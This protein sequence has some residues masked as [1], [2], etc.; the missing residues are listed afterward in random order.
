M[1]DV[2]ILIHGHHLQTDNWEDVV[3][4]DPQNGVLGRVPRA[5]R[6][7]AEYNNPLLFWGSGGSKQGKFTEA[8]MSLNLTLQRAQEIPELAGKSEI[9]VA[10]YLK[11]M[12]HLNTTALNTRQEVHA[13]AV[14]CHAQTIPKM[15]LVSSPTHISRCMLD[16][17]KLRADGHMEGIRVISEASD[18]SYDGYTPHDVVVVEPPHRGDIQQVEFHE[19]AKRFFQFNEHP[20]LAQD[21]YYELDL[22]IGKYEGKMKG[23]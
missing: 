20:E 5:L 14:V 18:V 23:T 15:I 19:I 8:E 4:G 9:E 1:H 10:E 22:L 3:W 11:S 6:I 7:A 21:L 2:L 12:L 17:Q 16:A 13:A